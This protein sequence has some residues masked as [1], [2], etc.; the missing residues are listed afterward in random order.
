MIS[1]LR[2]G[3]LNQKITLEAEK[4][5]SISRKYFGGL[6]VLVLFCYNSI[7]VF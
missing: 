1:I 3:F 7:L 5:G 2:G 6:C 4:C